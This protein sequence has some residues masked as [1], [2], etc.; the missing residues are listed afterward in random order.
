[1][2]ITLTCPFCFYEE[3]SE[4]SEDSFPQLTCPSCTAVLKHQIK[5]PPQL[6][7]QAKEVSGL[8]PGRPDIGEGYMKAYV[9]IG[10]L[11]GYKEAKKSS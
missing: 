7:M 4:L 3:T 1:M 8:V 6:I 10:Y 5:G 9:E 11:L 2:K